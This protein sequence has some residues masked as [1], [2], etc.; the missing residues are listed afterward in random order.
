MIA[1]MKKSSRRWI[2][3]FEKTRNKK[4]N[5]AEDE[6]KKPITEEDATPE[7]GSYS[8]HSTPTRVDLIRSSS[9]DQ[10]DDAAGDATAVYGYGEA[11][12]DDRAKYGYGDTTAAPEESHPNTRTPRRSSMKQSGRPRR[13]SIQFGGEIEVSLPGEGMPVRRRTSIVFHDQVKIKN[14][15]PV[16]EL[17]DEP[18]ALWFQNEEYSQIKQKIKCLVYKSE[19]GTLGDRK[20]CLRGL[21]RMLA[22]DVAREKKYKALDS[23][24]VEQDLQRRQGIY[25]DDYMSKL[26]KF[27]TSKCQREANNRANDDAMEIEN[28]LKNARQRCRR[29]SM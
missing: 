19:E 24:L 17:T 10:Q 4:K 9:T 11:S 1:S 18:K 7:T 20:Y 23:V 2:H 13:A 12:P 16:S 25:D 15:T 14:V 27:T 6:C 21:E 26:Y 8:S 29:L 22:S 3:P 5:V 28:Y